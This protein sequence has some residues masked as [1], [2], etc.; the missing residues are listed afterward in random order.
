M[1]EPVKQHVTISFVEDEQWANEEEWAFWTDAAGEF[2]PSWSA[3]C[4]D[5][6]VSVEPLVLLVEL[7][8]LR[9]FAKLRARREAQWRRLHPFVTEYPTIH[10]LAVIRRMVGRGYLAQRVLEMHRE[11]RRWQ[12]RR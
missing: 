5:I 11:R 10:G 7:C 1:S 2:I 4:G 9:R 8:Y 12:G 3:T 6:N